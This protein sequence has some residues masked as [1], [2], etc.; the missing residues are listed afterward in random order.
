MILTS[1]HYCAQENKI[2]AMPCIEPVMRCFTK[3]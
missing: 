1:A 3:K 2:K